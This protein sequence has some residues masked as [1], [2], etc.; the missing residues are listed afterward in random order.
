MNEL[1]GVKAV[2]LAIDVYPQSVLDKK[3]SGNKLA[4]Q[5]YIR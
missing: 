1:V 2:G 4:P 3:I 5:A